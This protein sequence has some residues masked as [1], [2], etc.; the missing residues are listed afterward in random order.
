MVQL[1][2]LVS[3]ARGLEFR[4]QSGHKKLDT[5]VSTDSR[6]PEERRPAWGLGDGGERG[7]GGGTPGP[8]WPA[9]V[10]SLV[11][12]RSEGRSKGKQSKPMACPSPLSKVKTSIG[13]RRGHQQPYSS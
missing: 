10:T 12:P 8:H 2:E 3:Q 6:S 11:S 13:L 7:C 9:S 1:A 4:V 5:V